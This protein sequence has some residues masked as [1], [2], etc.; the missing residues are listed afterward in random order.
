MLTTT[1][2]QAHKK[3][4]WA[5]LLLL[6]PALLWLAILYLGSLFG[7]LWQSAYRIDDFSGRQRLIRKIVLAETS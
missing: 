4:V 5:L 6:F 2:N 1:L 7:L 3:R